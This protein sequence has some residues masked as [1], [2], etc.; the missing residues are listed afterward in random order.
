MNTG[1]SQK[2]CLSTYDVYKR[3]GKEEILVAHEVDCIVASSITGFKISYISIYAQKGNYHKNGYKI[4]KVGES[5]PEQNG[6]TADM[7]K[8]WDDMHNAFILLMSGEGKIVTENGKKYVKP[9]CE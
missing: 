2:R 8:K 7:R 1:R 9:C 3:D 4:V 5:V 6:M